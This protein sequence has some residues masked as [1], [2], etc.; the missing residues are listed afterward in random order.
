[1]SR[2]RYSSLS[3]DDNEEDQHLSEKEAF[4]PSRLSPFN[5]SHLL[6][7]W[8]NPLIK[9]G[10]QF[11][12]PPSLYSKTLLSHLT[13]DKSLWRGLY[14]LI[15]ADF[16]LG[17]LYLLLNTI[18]L[19]FNTMLIK[20][21]VRAVSEKN[22]HKV[23]FLSVLILLSSLLQAISLQQ[24]IHLVFNCGS[25]VVSA[26][27]SRIFHACLS[28]RLHSIHPPLSLG[29]I[30]NIQGKDA[31]SMRDSIVFAHNLWNCP[32]LILLTLCLLTS[33]LG[34]IPTLAGALLFPLLL[35]IESYLSQLAKS[36]RRTASQKSDCRM[37]LINEMIE[38]I[39]TVKLTNLSRVMQRR[40][41]NI[42][43]EELSA[44]W[45]SFRIDIINTV[46]SQSATIMVTLVTFLVYVSVN[47]QSISAE[48]AFT[49]LTLISALGRPMKVLPKCISMYSDTLVAM[50]RI[51]KLL[52]HSEKTLKTCQFLENTPVSHPYTSLDDD[53]MTKLANDNREIQ[54]AMRNVVSLRPPSTIVL[55]VAELT[56]TGPG[57][58]L[59]H[60][61]NASGNP[62]YFSSPCVL[63]D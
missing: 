45:L 21:I 57:L 29:S 11:S 19:L 63:N 4:F 35:P 58:V 5:L 54:I 13:P 44:L 60:G 14:D 53:G 61:P 15:Q 59:L 6:F 42:R 34:I 2:Y 24:Y 37:N 43:N 49:S 25:R 17:G 50:Q 12:L 27:T 62:R 55:K 20:Y 32:M 9:E 52:L 3:E 16:L 8:V 38:G 46:I 48:H 26:L 28:L 1:M 33:L 40:I 30:Q 23:A 41:T 7:T 36:Y 31:N 47:R 22:P 18:L 51:D 39:R 56:L 10:K